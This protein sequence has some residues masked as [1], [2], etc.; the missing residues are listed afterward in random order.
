M[1][2]EKNPHSS[3]E[4][5]PGRS[6]LFLCLLLDIS[7]IAIL[8]IVH[9]DY[10]DRTAQV[11]SGI[12]GALTVFL[13][14]I[15]IKKGEVKS[16]PEFIGYIPV[17]MAI[18]T[19]TVLIVIFFVLNE[20]PVHA[21]AI[22]STVKGN[23]AEGAGITWAGSFEGAT[24][25]GGKLMIPWVRRGDYYLKA[26][27]EGYPEKQCTVTVGLLPVRH[28]GVDFR[29]EK[30]H[31]FVDSD[32]QD[33][34][35]WVDSLSTG[36]ETPATIH[37]LDAGK[38]TLE[39]R[40]EGYYSRSLE[41]SIKGDST[42]TIKP[43]PRLI[44]VPPMRGSIYITSEPSGA[45]IILDG[46]RQSEITPATIHNLTPGSH[47]VELRLLHKDTKYGYIIK[48]TVTV[49]GNSTNSVRADLPL[50]EL[51][52]LTVRSDPSGAEIY[53]DGDPKGQTQQTIV[54]FPG[55]RRI[56]L[57]KPGYVDREWTINVSESTVL[58][59]IALV[60]LTN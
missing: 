2:G 11:V 53:I 27:L 4:W 50:V 43:V 32:P 33:A 10:Y 5:T 22:T 44:K 1:T 24:R 14:Y 46:R 51:P 17:R 9:Y 56:A 16:L 19:Y 3:K 52:K 59:M 48:Q 57:R 41:V 7:V 40:K 37:D 30:G 45:L 36:L 28:F 8:L 15:G 21:V 38:Y 39:L 54:V 42:D 6:V 18:I 12:W 55:E 58:P 60:P 34:A 26:E 20:L 13:G 47:R 49:A 31:V 25:D 35:I 23:P 29:V